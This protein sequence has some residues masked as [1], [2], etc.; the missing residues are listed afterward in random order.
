VIDNTLQ[1]KDVERMFNELRL[2]FRE[3]ERLPVDELVAHARMFICHA[4]RRL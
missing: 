1:D 3:L 2:Y 4:L